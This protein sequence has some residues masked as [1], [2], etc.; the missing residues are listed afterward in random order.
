M[1]GCLSII[2]LMIFLSVLDVLLGKILPFEAHQTLRLVMIGICL[3]ACVALTWRG[4]E[5][6][7][8]R[9]IAL[10]WSFIAI[11]I[12]AFTTVLLVLQR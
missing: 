10:I 9:G 6:L 2:L 8:G 11:L 3:A 5:E 12:C 7:G 1:K 4:R